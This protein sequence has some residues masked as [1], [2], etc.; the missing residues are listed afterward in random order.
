MTMKDQIKTLATELGYQVCGITGIQPFEK[1]QTALKERSLR[2][3]E[4]AHLYQEMEQRIDPTTNAPW[5]K[6]IIVAVRRYGKYDLPDSITGHIGRNYLCDRRIKGCPDNALPKRMKQGLIALGHRVKIGGVPCREAAVRAGIVKIG[7]NGFAYADGCG[8]WL[9]IE[10][11]LID[12][13]LEPD[14]PSTQKAPCPP[15]CR[16]CL[17][18][19]RTGALAEPYVMNMKRCIARLTYGEEAPIPTD[20]WNKMGPWIYGC[21][22]CQT[23]CPMNHGKWSPLEPAPWIKDIAD[24]LTP[25]AL[26]SMDLDTYKKIIYPLFWY[27]SENDVER[28]HRN[29]KRVIELAKEHPPALPRTATYFE[30]TRPLLFENLSL[31]SE[32]RVMVLAPHPDDF[33]AISVTLRYLHQNGNPINLVVLT[34]GDS[35][36]EDDYANAHLPLTKA[37]IREIEQKASCQFFGRPAEHVQF[38]RFATDAMG[39]MLADT[40]NLESLRTSILALRPDIVF[41]PHGNDTNADHR[42]TYAFLQKCVQQ[43]KL[44]LVACL[45]R[46]PKTIAMQEDMLTLF[47]AET[48]EWKKEL[49]RF[50][51][52]QQQRNLR[53]RGHG[54]DDRVLKSNLRSLPA[55]QDSLPFAE[56]FELEFFS[57]E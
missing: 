8:S 30:G 5:A 20:L 55:G 23:A 4:A 1:Y 6:S 40:E 50:H 53:T 3:P 45:N 2:F 38:L 29:A 52:S 36:V 35:G 57:H 22:D 10:A 46:D 44:S 24:R 47:T 7:R 41:L 43:E 48:A 39:S 16:A 9:N 17:D 32:L 28:W 27:I 33:D 21:D 15:G 56:I 13:E 31:P 18:A 37:E 51:D 14:A 54:F 25:E 26:A 19:C 42:R 11:W 34:S 49:L 12:A